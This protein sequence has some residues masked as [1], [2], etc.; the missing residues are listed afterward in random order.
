MTPPA[1]REIWQEFHWAF[2]LDTQGLI[3]SLRRFALLLDRG[4]V[5]DAAAELEA[6]G[7]IMQASAAA[8]HLAGS[9]TRAAYEAE[10]RPSMTPPHVQTEGFSGLMSWEHG[11]LVALWRSLRPR[12]AALPAALAPAHARFIA[13]YRCMAEGHVA[14]C[15]RFVGDGS[16]SLRY[17]G[18]EAVASLRRF[19]ES[20]MALIDPAG[21]ASPSDAPGRAG[22]TP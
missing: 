20:R 1:P 6:A 9:F 17:E 14:V 11:V 10:V 22:G 8:M 13:A 18:R 21:A 19:G 3:L 2:F 4:A 15:A 12:F 7:E 16:A 5:E